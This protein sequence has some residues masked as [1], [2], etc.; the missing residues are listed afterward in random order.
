MKKISSLVLALTFIL[1][2]AGCSQEN[3]QEEKGNQVSFV[4]TVIEVNEE[5]L[6]VEVTNNADSALST[7]NQVYVQKKLFP[8]MGVLL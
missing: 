6:L 5:R 3:I 2:V 1:V 4:G 8:Q 7:G